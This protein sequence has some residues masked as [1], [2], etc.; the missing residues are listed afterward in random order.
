MS[1]SYRIKELVSNDIDVKRYEISIHQIGV[2]SPLYIYERRS[3]NY[4]GGNWLPTYTTILSEASDIL[5]NESLNDCGRISPGGISSKIVGFDFVTSEPIVLDNSDFLGN[6]LSSETIDSF[7]F[8]FL[9]CSIYG[10]KQKHIYEYGYVEETKY[11]AYKYMFNND[12][13]IVSACT[14]AGDTEHNT[15][16]CDSLILS[17]TI[18]ENLIPTDCCILVC[19]EP[20]KYELI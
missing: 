14:H 12:G 8:A 4:G 18:T 13:D 16:R 7:Q 6:Y 15:F 19:C 10:T 17:Y 2:Y 1:L 20:D 3:V 5:T 9:T 11:H